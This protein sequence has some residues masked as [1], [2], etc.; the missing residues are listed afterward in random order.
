MPSYGSRIGTLLIGGAKLSMFDLAGGKIC[1]ARKRDGAGICHQPAMPNGRCRLHGGKSTGPKNPY[2]KHGLYRKYMDEEDA[3]LYDELVN[4]AEFDD[5]KREI[6]M[7]R[8]MIARCFASVTME[9]NWRV[10]MQVMPS[11]VEKLLKLIERMRPSAARQV[12][13]DD[14]DEALQELVNEERAKDLLGRESDHEIE[15]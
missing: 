13:Q 7:I 11:Y 8:I 10:P 4:D 1:G 3:I 15:S 12:L 9:E 5:L 2:V 6:A 14:L